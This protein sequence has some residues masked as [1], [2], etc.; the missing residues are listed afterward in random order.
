MDGLRLDARSALP[1]VGSAVVL[2]A[3]SLEVFISVLLDALAVRQELAPDLWKWIADRD[4]KLLQQPSVEE[5]FDVLLKHLCG[6]SLKEEGTLWEAFKNLRSARN[7]FVHEGVARVGKTAV[8]K[9]EALTLV[10]RVDDIVRRIREWI[11]DDLRWPV[12]E[13]KAKLSCTQV[14]IEPSNK[15]LQPTSGGE[16]AVE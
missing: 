11:P 10:N 7:T 5:Q 14:L 15:P 8:T 13:V 3:T 9:E 12:P 6:H 1:N 16:L 4:G 2:A